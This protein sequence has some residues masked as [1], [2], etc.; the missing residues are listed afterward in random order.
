MFVCHFT[1]YPHLHRSAHKIT[2]FYSA[3]II[4]TM[5]K[6]SHFQ[7]SSLLRAFSSTSV[8]T[9]GFARF[10]SIL[11]KRDSDQQVKGCVF[12]AKRIRVNKTID[13]EST[14]QTSSHRCFSMI[15]PSVRT[16]CRY[17]NDRGS[18]DVARDKDLHDGCTSFWKSEQ[19]QAHN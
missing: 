17:G 13:K 12:V 15:S 3:N 18:S 6:C 4:Y 14:Q 5:S 2:R 16:V 1:L 7:K 9:I 8:L 10:Q 11:C 19:R